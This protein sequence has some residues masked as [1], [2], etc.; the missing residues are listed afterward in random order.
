MHRMHVVLWISVPVRCRVRLRI[1]GDHGRHL[2]WVEL[3][4]PRKRSHG[5][6]NRNIGA[7]MTPLRRLH[8]QRM[9]LPIREVIV[10]HRCL[11]A[12]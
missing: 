4:I 8:G 5:R 2:L 11:I 12:L 1:L 6:W 3:L 7:V 10:L 9:V